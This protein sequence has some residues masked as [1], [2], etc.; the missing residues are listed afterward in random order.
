MATI[1]FD[2]VNGT[3]QNRNNFSVTTSGGNDPATWSPG[4][5]FGVAAYGSWPQ[6]AGVPF[7]IADDS[8]VGISGGSP[9]AGDTLG[10]ID[11]STAATD[12][13]FSAVDI[14]NGVNSGGSGTATWEFDISSAQNGLFLSIDMAAMGDFETSDSYIW[15]YSIDGGAFQT[16]FV[17]SVDEAGDQNYTMEDGDI[18][19]L[20]DPMLINGVTLNDEFQTLTEAISGTGSTLTLQVEGT[21]DGGS[22]A[23]AAKN[24][25]IEEVATTLAI[26]PD[27][28]SQSEGNSGTTDFTF[29]VTRAG[30][31]T[32]AT[33]VNYEVTSGQANAA[34]FGGTLPSGTVSFAAG[35][36]SK[37]I[38]V[39]VSGDTDAEGDEV[40]T[41]TLTNPA[42]GETLTAATADSTITNDDG[43]AITKIH[44]I[45]GTTDTNLLD[46]QVV[47]IEAIVIGDFQ[48]TD[49]DTGRSIGGFFVQ[50]EDGD[51]DGNANTS[52]G[53]FI[54]ADGFGPDVNIGDKVQVTGTV[55]EFFGETQLDT[56]TD[57]TIVSSGNTLPTAAIINLPATGTSTD[58]DGDLQADLEAYEGMRVTFPDTLSVTEM[59]QLDRFNEVKLSQ[60]GTLDQFTQN[61]LPSVAGYNAHLEDIAQRT[62]TYDDGLNAQN[63]DIGNLDGFGPTYNTA[64]DIRMG[65]TVT[66]LT[67]VLDY[68]WAGN[69][70]ST[71]T[72]RV[73][74]TQDN[75][76]TFTKVN[77]RPTSPSDVGG[78]L[79]VASFNVLNFFTTL[80]QGSN[81][82][83]TGLDPRG[84]DNATEYA[85]QLEK[86]TTS[87]LEIDA[88]ILGL[89]EVEN[90]STSSAL[91]A[92]VT[93]L[94]NA[95]GATRTYDYVNTGLIGSD[96][97]AVGFIYDT[98]TVA[99]EGN[100]A[101]LDSNAFVDPNSTG[102]PRNRPAL[103]QTFKEVS[104]GQLFTP[105]VNHFKSKGPSGVANGSVDADQGDGQANWNDT[106]TKAAI[107][108]DAWLQTDP[109]GSGD[110]DFLILGDLNAYA[111]EDPITALEG[112]G[113]TDLA[114]QFIPNAYSFFFDGQK[115]TLDYA[116][117][118]APLLTQVTG[119]TEWHVNA[120]EADAIDYNTDFGRDTTIF[121]GSV[122][123]RNSDHD[124]VII[125]LDLECFLTGTHVATEHGEKRVEELKIGELVQT[126]DGGLDPIKWIGRQTCHPGY[127]KNP[128]RAYPIWIKAG[129]LGQGL[130][131]RDL[132]VSP[133][134][135]LLV[136]GLL[137]NAG[138]LVNGTSIIKTDPT[139]RFTYYHI[140][141]ER[142]ALLIAEGTLAESYFPQKEDRLAYDN[143][144]EYEELY[145]NGSKILLWPLDYPRVSSTT[146]VPR[147]V[148]KH[149]SK[150]ARSLMANTAA[151]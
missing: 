116:M 22:E 48:D 49:A 117:A 67:G 94:N 5:W 90:S 112:L 68:K 45:Q 73:R 87:L 11:S 135:A 123:Y 37:T 52:E 109:T 57:I 72:W 71:A 100:F 20:S 18:I 55:D 10:I 141:L 36:T 140:E 78:D 115:G 142:H 102:S 30:D 16:I 54:F 53:L 124:P 64:T 113:Y 27:T 15:S 97:I 40:F 122:P 92:I 24:I 150:I 34:D 120:D 19:N 98:A 66:N 42:N 46:G 39:A 84:A 79:T 81:T 62:I 17:S 83:D 91:D 33:S 32:G 146:T 118:N 111:K 2:L 89:V 139:E 70:A 95:P 108:L 101:V 63:A 138:A 6:G 50:E 114:D 61:N 104:T 4:D 21:S 26:A 125:G 31:T 14:V 12:T 96:A 56:I 43:T 51:A 93:A 88:D 28:P 1:A 103:A 126:A 133:D 130:P 110:P 82:T 132:Y 8:V 69:S 58:Q 134:H 35:E 7:A 144:A 151:G 127:V 47:T 38:T 99:T 76:N 119:A 77:N 44:D 147:F 60:G 3:N 106:R 128:L 136:E 9:F 148:R 13:F 145:P 107:A 105:V 85:R 25:V 23:F 149:L 59:F 121:D 74:A 143:G 137:I 41:V 131:H 65:D 29:T 86:L 80:D 129:A 75:T